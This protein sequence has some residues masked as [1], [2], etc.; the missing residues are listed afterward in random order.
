MATDASTKGG[1]RLPIIKSFRKKNMKNG[2][3]NG[4]I[5]ANGINRLKKADT[6]SEPVDRANSASSFGNAAGEK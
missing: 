2:E 6:L 1:L 4:T 5:I 3:S